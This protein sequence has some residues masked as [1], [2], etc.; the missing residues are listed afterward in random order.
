M[1]ILC[2]VRPWGKGQYS[3]IVEHAFPDAEIFY[4]SDWLNLG[5]EHLQEKFYYYYNN[6]TKVDGFLSDK[7]DDVLLRCRLLRELPK[8]QAVKMIYSMWSAICDVYENVEP[9]M[10]IGI[11]V[12]SYVIDLL[13]IRANKGGKRYV[14]FVVNFAKG[15]FRLTERG[16]YVPSHSPSDQEVESLYKSFIE[17]NDKPHFLK[18][19]ER[20]LD[21]AKIVLLSYLK[22]K[23]RYIYFQ[24]RKFF[25]SDKLNYHYLVNIVLS[26]EKTDW[27][28]MLFNKISWY[29]FSGNNQKKKI[30]IP[31][32]YF[33]EATVDYWVKN[34]EYVS[35][36]KTLFKV[37]EE[38]SNS[39]NY[40]IILKEHPAFLGQRPFGFNDRVTSFKNVSFAKPSIDSLDIIRFSDLVLVWTGTAGFEASIRGL[41]V[42]E[43]GMP[44][45]K[46]G[47]NYFYLSDIDKLKSVVEKIFSGTVG[48]NNNKENTLSEIRFLLQG[49]LKGD[50]RNPVR[51][52][53]KWVYNR[54]TVTEI[55]NSLREFYTKGHHEIDE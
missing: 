49:C 4:I 38:L 36:Y 15:Y 29:D 14:G 23:A 3:E 48:F 27:K 21:V 34:L 40:E 30:F 47:S 25:S 51:K 42:I 22:Q 32:Q 18:Q 55:A 8:Q 9:D 43:L 10:V 2:Y 41:P 45:Y 39:K 35:Y 17:D 28:S 37:L 31:L 11:T 16:E 20:G 6:E 50:F 24:T 1:K 46:S 12:D 19:P 52:R 54:G 7:I 33:P 26:R 53:G 5:S 44:Y 13:R